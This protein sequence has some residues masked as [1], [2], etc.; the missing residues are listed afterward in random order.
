MNITYNAKKKLA[1]TAAGVAAT[2]VAALAGVLGNAGTAQ[3]D[4]LPQPITQNN[5]SIFVTYTTAVGGLSAV[6]ADAKNPVGVTEHCHYHSEGT[7]TTPLRPFDGDAFPTG[8]D[9]TSLFIP[10]TPT[11][12]S[13]T[14]L[15]TCDHGGALNFPV[16]Y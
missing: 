5:G 6:I 7:G 15:V 3:A 1:T 12:G 11:G 14:V 13:Y 9:N 8:V 2:A 4:P 16:T 10:G